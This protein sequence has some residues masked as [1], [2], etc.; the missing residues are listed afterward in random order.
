VAVVVTGFATKPPESATRTVT[1]NVP[2][3]AYA[4]VPLTKNVTPSAVLSEACWT[5]VPSPQLTVAV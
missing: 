4:W 3:V 5:A 1:V 2:L